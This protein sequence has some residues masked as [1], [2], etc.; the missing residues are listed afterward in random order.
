MYKP[1]LRKKI[2]FLRKNMD[3]KEVALKSSFIYK[4]IKNLDYYKNSNNV[5]AYSSMGNEVDVEELIKFVIL[6]KG[7]IILPK[8]MNEFEIMPFYVY[9]LKHIKKGAYNIY[10][11]DIDICKECQI[12]DLDI[13]FVPGVVFSRDA[14]RIGM[15]QGYYDR[16]LDRV[17]NENKKQV[18]F[19]GLGYEFQ[20]V[21]NF[22]KD[23]ND[24]KLDI[25]ITEKSC[26]SNC[27]K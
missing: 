1:K 24:I 15:G 2:L 11:P 19:I 16:F 5:M 23:Y 12:K 22:E 10:E 13:I 6:D 18:P 8:V 17:K 7:H 3:D 20:V 14:D 25:I 26:Y 4:K 9:S 27:I 21:E